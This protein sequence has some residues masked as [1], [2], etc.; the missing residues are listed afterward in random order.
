MA[1]PLLTV[2]AT[3]TCPHG[4]SGS[5]VPAQ[6]T[7]LARSEVCT[8]DDQIVIA[9]CGFNVSGSPSPCTTVQWKT[10]SRHCTSGGSAVL[11]SSSAGVCT[12]TAGAPQGPVTIVPE[13]IAA[14]AL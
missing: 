4:G 10:T 13:Q 7:A 11:T 2:G 9:G 14:G 8:E 3:L 12:N 1:D 5:I 6:T